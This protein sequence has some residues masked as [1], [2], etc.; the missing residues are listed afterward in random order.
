MVKN[1][2]DKLVQDIVNDFRNYSPTMRAAGSSTTVTPVGAGRVV[3]GDDVVTPRGWVDPPTV[4]Q[5]KPPGL[6]IMD[7]MVDQQDRIDKAARARE[8][9]EAARVE[10]ELRKLEKGRK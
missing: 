8:L 3:S 10:K 1:V 4:D 2:D 7:A 9:A 5:W 6:E